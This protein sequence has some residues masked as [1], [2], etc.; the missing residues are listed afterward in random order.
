MLLFSPKLSIWKGLAEADSPQRQNQAAIYMLPDPISSAEVLGGNAIHYKV[1]ERRFSQN[2]MKCYI[3]HRI[4]KVGK[5]YELYL[6]KYKTQ[7]N[8]DA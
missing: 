4:I 5:C 7:I 3:L 8:T 1:P 6:E 2:C